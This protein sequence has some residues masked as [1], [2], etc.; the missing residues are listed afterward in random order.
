MR[1]KKIIIASA[2]ALGLAIS[3]A[4]ATMAATV[5]KVPMLKALGKGEGALNIVVWAG[6]AENGSTDKT[7][8]WVNPFTKATG[9]Q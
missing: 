2:A 5:P 4:T 6:Y 1:A 7:V 3:A 9:C 8:D